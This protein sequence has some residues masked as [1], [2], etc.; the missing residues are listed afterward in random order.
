[1]KAT[2]SQKET[3][4]VIASLEKQGA[5]VNKTKNGVRV[6]FPNGSTT[7]IHWTTSDYRAAKNM[8]A[9]IKR[10]GLTWPFD[11]QRGQIMNAK[12]EKTRAKL[13][14]A[15]ARFPYPPPTAAIAEAAGLSEISVLRHLPIM[16]Y[17]SRRSPDR[18]GFFWSKPGLT[19]P[20]ARPP[21]VAAPGFDPFPEVVSETEPSHPEI[22]RTSDGS[23]LVREQEREEAEESTNIAEIVA[24]AYPEPPVQPQ[25]PRGR[26]FIDSA[27]SWTIEVPEK[28]QR[29]AERLGL[30]IEVRVWR[31]S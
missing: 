16:G 23:R 31:D 15:M 2:L 20:A 19:W 11:N 12:T 30:S 6:L 3:R 27:D 24:D 8:R 4:Q 17:E 18:R 29:L 28:L 10:A 21:Q 9:D 5:R 25:Q 14:E 13:H 22:E 26:E 7:A 1:V